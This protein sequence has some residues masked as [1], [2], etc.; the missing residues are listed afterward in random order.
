MRQIAG[1]LLKNMIQSYFTELYEKFGGEMEV[2]ENL[3]FAMLMRIG[4][5]VSQQADSALIEGKKVFS[6][7]CL[8]ISRIVKKKFF[9]N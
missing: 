7:L 8:I 4:Q 1:I 3:L 9:E 5:S 6:E 2:I